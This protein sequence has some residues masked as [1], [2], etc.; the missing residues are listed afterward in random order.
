MLTPSHRPIGNVKMGA[1][2][3]SLA[4]SSRLKV[5]AHNARAKALYE[6]LGYVL[7]GDTDGQLLYS[8]ALGK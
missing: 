4:K 3:R 2:G 8:L 5:Y 7:A 1:A 6:R